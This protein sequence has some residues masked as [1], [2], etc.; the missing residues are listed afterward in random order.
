M[1][2]VTLNLWKN[3]GDYERRMHAASSALSAL[4]PDVL[5][6]QEVFRTHDDTVH[7]ARF[8][9]GVLEMM[10]AYAPARS[11]LRSWGGRAVASESGLA[12]L[13]R[14]TIHSQNRLPLPSDERGGERI[15]LLVEARVGDL[16]VFIG[17]I[18]LS[19]LRDDD[20]TRRKQLET[21]LAAPGWR[22]HA[23]LRVLGGDCNAPLSSPSLAWI[24]EHPEL[25]VRDTWPAVGARFTH[26]IPPRVGRSARSID[27][28]FTIV[29]RHEV[30]AIETETRV[31]FDEP[32]GDVYVSD[33]AAVLVDIRRPGPL[34]ETP[35][36]SQS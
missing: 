9:A 34:P 19:H 4:A 12:V 30:H 6:L 14:G 5:L 16:H 36:D 24:M 17:C 23:D 27:H 20:A 33:H 2:V 8:L 7:S 32:I 11:K 15:A 28:V 35:C 13:V 3:E 18:H 29:P 22:E 31:T 21:V 1:R 26:P 10:F 25:L